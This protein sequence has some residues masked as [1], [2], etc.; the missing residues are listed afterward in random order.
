M[1]IMCVQLFHT[2]FFSRFLKSVIAKKFNHWMPH[3]DHEK[4]IF[5]HFLAKQLTGNSLLQMSMRYMKTIELRQ[6][7][8]YESLVVNFVVN[9]TKH[10][11][12]TS[13]SRAVSRMFVQ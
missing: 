10:N 6:S 4:I 7:V 8:V 5:S 12:F 11:M 9:I 1:F 3:D 13:L 2:H